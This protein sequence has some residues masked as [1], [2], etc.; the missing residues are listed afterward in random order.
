MSAKAE[1]HPK[2][3]EFLARDSPIV[4]TSKTDARRKLYALHKMLGGGELPEEMTG[5]DY[6]ACLARFLSFKNWDTKKAYK[7]V[8][9]AQKVRMELNVS[10]MLGFSDCPPEAIKVLEQYY[11]I[12][13]YGLDKK[14]QPLYVE[15]TG[16]AKLKKVLDTFSVRDVLRLHGGQLEYLVRVM[17]PYASKVKGEAV[18]QYTTVLDLKGM[19]AWAFL[20]TKVVDA[21]G[22]MMNTDQDVYPSLLDRCFIVNA[23][24]LF[25]IVWPVAKKF[26]EK[27]VVERITLLG[28]LTANPEL[29]LELHAHCGV[30]NLPT[31]LGGTREESITETMP[32][33][34]PADV[35]PFV[36]SALTVTAKPVL[37]KAAT[38]PT[39]MP[40][41]GAPGD[42]SSV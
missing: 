28:D 26:L 29:A 17:F 11:N 5:G 6:G 3:E 18:D 25:S 36:D 33:V 22:K 12:C 20:A 4:D 2:I 1:S 7:Q 34:I 24:K 38:M 39:R 21:F 30:E 32:W 27:R 13:Y 31:S 42:A 35:Q 19:D 16:R 40:G 10:A 41:A 15:A 8:R 37:K 14:G 9:Y 23:P